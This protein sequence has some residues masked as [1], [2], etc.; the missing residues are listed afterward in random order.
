M[1]FLPESPRFLIHKGKTLDAFRVWKRIRGV[2]TTESKEEF[3]IMAVAVHQE[4][5][6]VTEIAQNRR[7]PWMDFVTY[8]YLIASQILTIV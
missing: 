3:Y 6:A 5:S 2:E 7:F 1:L 4:A 8:V